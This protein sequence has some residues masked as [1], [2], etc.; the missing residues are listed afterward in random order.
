M[1]A[2][3][4]SIV[5]NN[6]LV[7]PEIE[8]AC[9]GLI[10]LWIDSTPPKPTDT[11]IVIGDFGLSSSI[12]LKPIRV[13]DLGIFDDKIQ[14]ILAKSHVALKDYSVLNRRTFRAD[15]TVK[16]EIIDAYSN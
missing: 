11:W 7:P 4:K 6:C 13:A 15:I 8:G 2:I 14:D 16:Q 5:K 10:R 3:I 1:Q 9:Y 12:D